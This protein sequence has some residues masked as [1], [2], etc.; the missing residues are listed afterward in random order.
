MSLLL[1]V[2][3]AVVMFELNADDDKGTGVDGSKLLGIGV[4]FESLTC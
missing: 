4:I 1:A 3:L 2:A